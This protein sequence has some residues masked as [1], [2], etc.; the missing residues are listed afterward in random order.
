MKGWPVKKGKLVAEDGTLLA[1]GVTLREA[2]ERFPEYVVRDADKRTDPVD[3]RLPGSY[4]WAVKGERVAAVPR[5]TPH[6]GNNGNARS[7][8]GL[9][10]VRRCSQCRGSRRARRY[11]SLSGSV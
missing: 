3:H 4:G 6:Y 8:F 9:G 11:S 7:S 10:A 2:Q 1:S 5:D